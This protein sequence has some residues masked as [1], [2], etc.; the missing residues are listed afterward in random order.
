M[1]ILPI[2]TIT[3]LQNRK[4]NTHLFSYINNFDK[5]TC[6]TCK[7]YK[8]EHYDSFDSITSKCSFYGNKN[9]SF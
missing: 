4:I 3:L 1:K 2:L 5:P 8:P 7:F 9:L 6:I